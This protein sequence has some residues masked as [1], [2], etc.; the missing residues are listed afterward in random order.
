MK[1]VP[2]VLNTTPRGELTLKKSPGRRLGSAKMPG[3]PSQLISRRSPPEG[4]VGAS[5][6]AAADGQAE[7]VARG[8]D[9]GGVG[10]RR[11]E[12]DEAGPG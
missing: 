12:G 2:G 1:P 6:V 10:A 7:G 8:G 11:F 3:T 4:A 5:H 9:R